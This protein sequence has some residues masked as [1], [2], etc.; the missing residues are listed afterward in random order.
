[1]SEDILISIVDD[2]ASIRE[3]MRAILRS[4]GYKVATFSSA[5]LF[6]RS[7]EMSETKCVIADLEMPGLNGL[8]LQT[9][10]KSRGHRTPVIVI[11]GYPDEKRRTDALDAGAIGFLSKPFDVEALIECVTAAISERK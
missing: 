1:M 7:K 9:E 2:Q 3:A 6:L 5:E 4:Y 11:T 8:R 10:L